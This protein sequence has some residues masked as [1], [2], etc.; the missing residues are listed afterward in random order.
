MTRGAFKMLE[1]DHEFAESGDGLTTMIDTMRFQAPGGPVGRLLETF[2]VGPH[3]RR[4][5]QKRGNALKQIAE[6]D[7]WKRFVPAG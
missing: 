3:L 7:Q 5:L 2:L 1:H 6:S 4:F